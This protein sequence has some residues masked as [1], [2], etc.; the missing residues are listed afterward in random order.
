M[1]IGRITLLLQYLSYAA[2]LQ[3]QPLHD[4]TFIPDVVHN[5][6]QRT[7]HSFLSTA[8]GFRGIYFYANVL[9]HVM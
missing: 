2:A 4:F 1:V 9:P 5:A 6:V 3:H 7:S 8:C